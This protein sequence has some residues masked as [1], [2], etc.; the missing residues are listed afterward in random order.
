MKGQQFWAFVW[1]RWRLLANQARQVLAA[2]AKGTTDDAIVTKFQNKV[3]ETPPDA[4]DPP[5][6]PP[7]LLTRSVTVTES[8]CKSLR[9]AAWVRVDGTGYCVRYWISK[10]R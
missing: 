6:H 10:P 1:L 7:N 2:C 5:L 8:Q 3:P 9:T 4:D